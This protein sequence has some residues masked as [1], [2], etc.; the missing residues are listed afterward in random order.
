MDNPYIL[1]IVKF[2][3]PKLVWA[4]SL[5][6][7]GVNSRIA[8]RECKNKLEIMD[9]VRRVKS[10]CPP[11]GTYARL[12]E[13]V[14]KCYALGPFPALWAVEGL[15]H[16]YGDTFY[17]RNE[18]P[19]NLLTDEKVRTLP[20]KSLTMLHAGIGMSFAKHSLEKVKRNSAVSEVRKSV[21]EFVTL[22]R[23][24]SRTGYLGAAIESLGLVTRFLHGADTLRIVDQQLSEIDGNLVGYLWHGAGRALYFHPSNF[25][26]GFSSPWRAFS[27]C[28]G[29]APHDLARRNLLAGL[30]WAITLV[31]MKYPEIME[32]VL[33]NYGEEFSKE[34]TFSNGVTSSIIMR[35]DI[36]PDD[37]F[38]QPFCRYQPASSDPDL[39]KTW[40]RVIKEPCEKALQ[41]W[42]PALKSQDRL[43]EVFHYRALSEL[44]GGTKANLQSKLSS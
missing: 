19:R 8:W 34:D 35:Y 44:A 12:P 33:K 31:N 10:V 23:E 20:A 3:M 17:E 27:M 36:T 9:L 26:P 16:Y 2:V 6:I 30:A 32:T 38:I 39:V 28:R 13:L 25:I 11:P 1:A 29:E 41:L 22:C 24:S 14:P 43:E 37:P 4:I 42:Y 21:E 15:G 5:F 18:A 40:N 7:P